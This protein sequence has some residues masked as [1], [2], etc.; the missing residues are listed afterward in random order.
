MYIDLK[1]NKDRQQHQDLGI[2]VKK[3]L[4]GIA[5]TKLRINLFQNKL[6]N[7]N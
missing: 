1:K 4:Y 7:F 5:K 6:W 2:K 3:S